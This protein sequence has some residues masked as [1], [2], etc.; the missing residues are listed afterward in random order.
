MHY[1]SFTFSSGIYQLDSEDNRGP[2]QKEIELLY[3][4]LEE[5]CLVD[6]NNCYTGYIKNKILR[7]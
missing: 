3:G 4:S 1:V 7:L 6:L 2:Q 5:F